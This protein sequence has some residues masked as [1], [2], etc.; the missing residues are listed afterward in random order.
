MKKILFAF[1]TLL[2]ATIV[3]VSCSNKNSPKEVAT[4]W[5]NGF[6]HM[7]YAAA[8]KVSTPETDTLISQLEQLSGM[9]TTDS[10]RKEMKKIVITVKDVKEDGNKAVATYTL[11][12]NPSKEQKIDLVKKDGKWLVA[13]DKGSAMGGGAADN[14]ADMPAESDTTSASTD[15]TAPDT[16][17]H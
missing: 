4:T 3:I 17:K 2:L 5:L 11:S 15:V 14:P 12:E 13:F 16:T 6:Y 8:K 9:M 1:S 10:S 7:D